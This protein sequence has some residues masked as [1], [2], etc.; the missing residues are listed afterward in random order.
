MVVT[1][2]SAKENI[3]VRACL[4]IFSPAVKLE[5][6]FDPPSVNQKL[7]NARVAVIALSTILLS[8]AALSSASL[9]IITFVAARVVVVYSIA[10]SACLIGLMVNITISDISKRINSIFLDTLPFDFLNSLQKNK[11]EIR[12]LIDKILPFDNT[13][14]IVAMTAFSAGAFGA[15]PV[16]LA[17]VSAGILLNSCK[18]LLLR[19]VMLIKINEFSEDDVNFPPIMKGFVKNTPPLCPLRI[20]FPERRP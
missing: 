9:G 12:W 10:V 11:P 7:L 19:S 15:G 13:L 5:R 16:T 2:E 17:V 1:V 20:L 18:A 8:S 14:N 4:S 3:S 6:S